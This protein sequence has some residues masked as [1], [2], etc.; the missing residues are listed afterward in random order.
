MRDLAAE[1]ALVQSE[2]GLAPDVALASNTGNWRIAHAAS[3]TAKVD[4]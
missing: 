2:G 1:L 3:P 4:P